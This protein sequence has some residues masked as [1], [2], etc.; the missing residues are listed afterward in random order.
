MVDCVQE[1]DTDYIKLTHCTDPTD[2]REHL[3]SE[4]SLEHMYCAKSD[5]VRDIKSGTASPV[6][7]ADRLIAGIIAA[8]LAARRR[9]YSA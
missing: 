2:H 3:I 5:T 9:Q 1:I 6:V 4:V 8:A 7:A